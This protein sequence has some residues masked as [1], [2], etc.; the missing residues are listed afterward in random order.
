[1]YKILLMSLIF[2]NIVCE[3]KQP[4]QQTD[5]A[6]ILGLYQLMK[7]VHEVF[8]AKKITYWIDSGTLLG[9]VR[10]KGIIPWDNDL[11]VCVNITDRDLLLEQIPLFEKLNITIH[12]YT[13]GYQFR[14]GEYHLDVFFSM[15]VNDKFIYWAPNIAEFYAMRDGGPV[16]YTPEELFPLKEYPFGELLVMGP[17]N[18]VP[19]LDVYY[20]DWH[21]TGRV[22]VDHEY[23]LYDP[24]AITLTDEYRVPAKPTGP[25][26][27]RTSLVL[28]QVE[29]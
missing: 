27:D 20:K 1:M 4:V 7:D 14:S 28:S 6:V 17:N 25:I 2:I 21:S 8:T 5:E 19:Y 3:A 15:R 12:Q 29:N 18:P 11:D 23:N 26:I 10:H 24:N 13:W 9:A 22:Q 16:Y